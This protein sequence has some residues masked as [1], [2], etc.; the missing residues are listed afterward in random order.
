M[1]TISIFNHVLGPVMRGPS[2]SH[3]A[4]A[5]HIGCMARSILG[6]VPASA[7]LAFDPNGSYCVTYVPQ[8][9][10]RGF[11]M[12]LM[13]KDL[14]DELFHSSLAEA[15]STGLD[16]QFEVRPLKH[17][18]HPNTVEMQLTGNDG[19]RVEIVARSV[20]GGEVEIT[21]IDHVPVLFNGTAWESLIVTSSENKTEVLD[22]LSRK[23]TDIE[24]QAGNPDGSTVRLTWSSHE[25]LGL[26][27]RKVLANCDPEIRIWES[28]PVY[29]PQ[30]KEPIY[31]S[32][33][34][35]VQ[36]CEER[37]VSLGQLALEYESHLLGLTPDEVIAESL[38]RY[39]IMVQSVERGL[40]LDFK[41]L[42]LLPACAG[43]IFAAESEGKLS[44]RSLHTRAAARAMA[45][46]HVDG[47]MG[48]VCAAP[49]GGSAGVIPGALLTLV[50]ERN[51]DDEQI[52]KAFLTAG[53]IGSILAIRATFAAEVAGCQVEIGA[54]GAMAA[55]AIVDAVGGSARQACDAAAI[56]FQN[57]MGTVCDLL[58]GMVEIPCHTRNGTAAASAFVNADLVLGG[59]P[60]PIPL[61]ET[62]DAVYAVGLAMPSELRCTSKGG[63][64]VTPSAL[65]LLDSCCGSG[66]SS[67]AW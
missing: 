23:F 61:D 50:E 10:D 21:H 2:S 31:T 33:A 44:V 55:A 24:E 58:H 14:T 53:A 67:C 11:A 5:Y 51:L 16:L 65:A 54:S 13:G 56:S 22:L 17:A 4:G 18:D 15:A 38:R 41:G 7:V 36:M 43:A 66:C 35:I 49:T 64:A 9:A 1:K 34:Q 40:A 46:M 62:I 25:S 30:Q 47:A 12:G 57:T 48:V 6:S 3:T 19:R 42:Q 8:G 28:S 59:Y 63:L 37:Q 29:F 52:A 26:E 60:N 20:G 39:S 45:V 32:A 27:M